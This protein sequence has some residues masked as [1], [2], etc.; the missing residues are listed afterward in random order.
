M[1]FEAMELEKEVPKEG[2]EMKMRRWQ[3]PEVLQ[4]EVREGL[5][6]KGNWDGRKL[7]KEKYCEVQEKKVF[8]DDWRAPNVAEEWT[9]GRLGIE[10]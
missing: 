9:K 2:I 1:V 3:S 10:N 8:Q 4:R 5:A 7:R 6:G